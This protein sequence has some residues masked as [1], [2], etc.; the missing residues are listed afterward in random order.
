VCG[1]GILGRGYRISTN[2]TTSSISFPA[3]N[4]PRAHDLD[5]DVFLS[6]F[7]IPLLVV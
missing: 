5:F 2:P 7:I 4:L 6:E 1:F 3:H